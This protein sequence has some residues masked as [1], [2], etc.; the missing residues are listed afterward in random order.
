MTR[1]L[2]A[3]GWLSRCKYNL[4]IKV[5]LS[6]RKT[7]CKDPLYVKPQTWNK[8]RTIEPSQC[9]EVFHEKLIVQLLKKFAT[10]I[11]SQG[12]LF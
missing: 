11:E 3:D 1:Y 2:T 6:L 5:R 12:V 7:Q 10:F 8:R 4:E 9:W